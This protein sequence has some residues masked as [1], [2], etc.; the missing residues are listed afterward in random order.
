MTYGEL[1][2]FFNSIRDVDSRTEIYFFDADGNEYGIDSVELKYTG[3]D[4]FI[5]LEGRNQNEVTK[6]DPK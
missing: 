6:I 4:F 5:N 1:C 3:E 2:E